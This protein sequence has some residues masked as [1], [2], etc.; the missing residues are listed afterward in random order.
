MFNVSDTST[1]D[2]VQ[3]TFTPE[4]ELVLGYQ[5]N[6]QHIQNTYKGKF[7]RKGYYE[8]YFFR[9]AKRIPLI[10]A[11]VFIERIRLAKTKQGDVMIDSKFVNTYRVFIFSERKKDKKQAFFKARQR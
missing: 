10:Y 4:N 2:S 5:V 9:E 1:V 11:D 6:A 3:I 7:R 8:Y